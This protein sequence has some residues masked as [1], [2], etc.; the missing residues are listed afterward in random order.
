M[1][2]L[3]SVVVVVGVVAALPQLATADRRKTG[4]PEDAVGVA[5]CDAAVTHL[6][7][8]LSLDT[9]ARGLTARTVLLHRCDADRW[10]RDAKVCFS[11]VRSGIEASLCL[12]TLSKTQRKAV[13]GDAD[14]LEDPRLA[15]WL[16][17]G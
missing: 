11:A 12:D 5:S 15:R 16:L 2:R 9:R 6:T 4:V 7:G 10:S 3:M 13:D 8:A 17:R 14:R 1:Q